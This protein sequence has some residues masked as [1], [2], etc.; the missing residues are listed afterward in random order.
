MLEV[1]RMRLLA[2]RV[3]D[4]CVARRVC[5]QRSDIAGIFRYD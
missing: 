4:A 2:N 1:N 3:A 5:V